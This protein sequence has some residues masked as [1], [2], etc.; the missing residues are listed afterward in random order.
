MTN[1]N[2]EQAEKELCEIAKL[3]KCGELKEWLDKYGVSYSAYSN[4][5][6]WFLRGFENAHRFLQ[7]KMMFNACISA[8]ESG[9]LAKQP[10]GLAKKCCFWAAVAAIA[11]CI[12]VVLTLIK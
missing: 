11:A 7:T 10:C 1:K 8:S 3:K 2:I 12:S 9:E 5:E 4:N 6:T